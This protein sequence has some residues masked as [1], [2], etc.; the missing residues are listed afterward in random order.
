M[1]C[2][3]FWHAGSGEEDIFNTKMVVTVVTPPD[4][5]DHDLYKLESTL[6]Q[7]ALM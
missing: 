5:K 6:Y 3:K 4:P 1:I 2:T 7:K